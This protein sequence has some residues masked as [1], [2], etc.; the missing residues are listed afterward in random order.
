MVRPSLPS[1]L[2]RSVTAAVGTVV[3]QL[4]G[5]ALGLLAVAHAVL[6]AAHLNLV[7]GA[8]LVLVVGAA[9]HG[10]LDA[11]IGLIKHV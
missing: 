7:Q 1:G 9:G 6:G 8:G 5:G 3:A 4:E 2:T 10:T 11:G